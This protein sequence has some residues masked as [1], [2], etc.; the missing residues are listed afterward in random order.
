MF[1]HNFL[2]FFSNHLCTLGFY[3]T[4]NVVKL[5]LLI[6]FFNFNMFNVCVNE[7]V[8]LLNSMNYCGRA[9]YDDELRLIIRLSL[10]L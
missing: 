3:V 5:Y 2:S 8:Q 6:F 10:L 1:L 7:A 9:D 4:F